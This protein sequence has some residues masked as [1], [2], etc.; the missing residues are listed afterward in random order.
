MTNRVPLSARPAFYDDGLYA[1][2]TRLAHRTPAAVDS[3]ISAWS[4]YGLALFAV[5]MIIAWWRA[6]T[7]GLPQLPALAVPAVVVL[8]YAANDALKSQVA[9]QRPCQVLPVKPLDPCP[10]LGDWSF[11]SNH[12][13]I[14]AAAAAA[15]WGI[16]RLLGWIAASAALLMAASRVWI[17]AHYP[18]DALAGLLVGAVFGT[19]LIHV[20]KRSAPLFGRGRDPRPVSAR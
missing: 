15:L 14:A 10:A 6:R 12:A 19:L 3:V 9:E 5:L 20:A 18:H 4:E 1:S 2:V 17:G 13:A 7:A 8:T 16:A 11:P